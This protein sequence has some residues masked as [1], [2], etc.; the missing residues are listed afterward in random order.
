MPKIGPKAHWI[1]VEGVYAQSLISNTPYTVLK[2]I[3]DRFWTDLGW[4]LRPK[5]H[6]NYVRGVRNQTLRIY[7]LDVDSMSF[8][9]DFRHP[10]LPQSGAK[11][12]PRRHAGDHPMVAEPIFEGQNPNVAFIPCGTVLQPI[13]N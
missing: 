2:Q 7:T 6:Q 8:R 11:I 10:K 3:F 13:L 4:P 5:I 1:N 9:T 12:A